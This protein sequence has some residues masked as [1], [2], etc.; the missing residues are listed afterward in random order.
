MTDYQTELQSIERRIEEIV[1]GKPADIAWGSERTARLLYLRFQHISLTGDIARLAR[2]DLAIDAAI[3]WSSRH[4]DLWLLKA[5]IAIQLHR[6]SDAQIYLGMDESL[7]T[8]AAGQLV[9]SDVDLQQGR[10]AASRAEV[11]TA[12]GED[13]TWDGLARLAHLHCVLGD[14]DA[15]DRIY[16]EA[17]DELT[18]KQMRAYAWLEVQRGRMYFQRG[19]HDRALASY[20]RANAA[21]SG[22]WLVEQSIAELMGAQ[23]RFG[24]AISTYTRLY[25]MMP[26]PEWEQALG[27]LY[28]LSGDA[29]LAHEWKTRALGHY[30]E[31]VSR[32][33][34]HYFHCLVELYNELEGQANLALEWARKDEDMRSNYMTQGDLAWASYRNGDVDS[35][36]EWMARALSSGAVSA[37]LYLQAACIYAAAGDTKESG[38]FMRLSMATNPAPAKACLRSGSRPLNTGRDLP[39]LK[40]IRKQAGLL[41]VGCALAQV[42]IGCSAKQPAPGT[43]PDEPH[44]VNRAASSF[45][46]AD[47]DYFHDMDG[48][49]PL[50]AD[51]IKGRNTWIVWTGGDDRLWDILSTKSVGALDFLKTLSSHPSL[52]FSRDNRWNYLGLVNEPCFEK[53]TGPDPEKFNLWL[54]KRSKD[55]PPDPF[56]NEAKYPGVKVGARGQ[57]FADGKTFPVGSYYGYATG[58]VGLRL[59]PNPDFDEAAYKKW[60]ANKYYTDAKYYNSKD[61]VRPYRVGMSCGFCHIGPSPVKPPEDPEN[62]KWENLASNVG[63]QYF[64]VDRIFSWQSDPKSYV[65]QMF[66]TSRPGTLDTSLVSSDSINNPRTMNAVYDLSARLEQAHRFGKETLAGGG[67]NNKQ[68]NDYVPASSPLATFYKPPD[69]VFSPRVLKDGSDSVGALGALNRVYL[70]IGLFSEEWLLH[71]NPLI[72]GKKFSPIEISVAE[73]NSSYWQATEAQTPDMALFFLKSTAPHKLKDAPGGEAYLSKDTATL[74]R[75]KVVFAERC[76]RCHSSKLPEKVEGLDPDGCSGKDYLSCWNK[77]WQWTKTEDFKAKMRAIVNRPDFLDN[78]FLAI[79]DRVPVTLL[80]TNACS[81]LATNAIKDNIWD[82]FS[83]Q[84]YKDLPS[85]GTITVYN[86]MT[87]APQPYQMPGGGRG[88]TRPASLISVWSTAPFLLNN[89]VGK[90]N[91]SPSVESRMDSFQDSIEKMLWPEKRDKD[92]VLGDKVPGTIDRTTMRSYLEVAPGYI[93]DELRPLNGWFERLFPWAFDNDGGIEIG[94]IPADTPVNLIAN[95]MI[96]SEDADFPDHLDHDRRV[97][98]LL[99]KIKHDLA[100]LPKDASDDDAKKVLANLVGPLMDLSKCPDYVVNRGHYFGTSAFAEEPGLSDNDKRALIEFI[101][102]F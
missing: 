62:P 3:G 67:L 32:G 72:G 10:Y 88:Y 21:Y 77:Y 60:D 14:I 47:E 91:S 2:L 51:E 52:K 41:L 76:A 63:A 56:E 70:N 80:Q 98:E 92:K 12:L 24:E 93:P 90:F 13:L 75:G 26:K 87:G 50:T 46:G 40:M 102:T 84:T 42:F 65:T 53:A 97:F 59:F 83:S 66:H 81:P 71:F 15:A 6:F 9:Q 35:A 37:R 61:L 20:Q 58:I 55:C 45:P 38:R 96:R 69:T 101:K 54:D 19:R 23:G 25:A 89:S 31:S 94:P 43:V 39:R 73:K 95:L 68:F 86:P 16:T 79:E 85:V 28:S 17:Q 7:P 49:L 99:L 5:Y 18:A 8:S 57:T 74:A 33:G 1:D 82:N 34:V 44:S 29:R 11:E 36:L 22:Y 4:A 78:N 27:E 48:A 100:S 64:W 30:L